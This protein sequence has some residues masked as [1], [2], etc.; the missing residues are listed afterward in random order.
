[1]T[2]TNGTFPLTKDRQEI[3]KKAF[4]SFDKGGSGSLDRS[5][6]LALLSKHFN[7]GLEKAPT[8]SDVE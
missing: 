3:M 2:L 5:E 7:L 6:I 8:K 1:M 4:N